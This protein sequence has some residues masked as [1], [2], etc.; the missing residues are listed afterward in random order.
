MPAYTVR[1]IVV[2]ND[3]RFTEDVSVESADYYNS[4]DGFMTFKN[5]EHKQVASFNAAHVLS[6]V[7]SNE[8]APSVTYSAEI[9]EARGRIELIRERARGY[10]VRS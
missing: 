7:R 4:D 9:D 6:I 3:Q 5:S 8:Q 1:I 10:A 2:E